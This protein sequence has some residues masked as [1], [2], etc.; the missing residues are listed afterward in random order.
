[1]NASEF[2]GWAIPQLIDA[3]ISIKLLNKSK[4]QNCGGWFSDDKKELVTC[5]KHVDAFSIFIHEFC[6]FLQFRDDPAMWNIVGTGT[7]NFF[8][9][10]KGDKATKAEILRFT[11]LA[12][13]LEHD[14]ET[15]A[16]ALIK[17]LNID[18]D[19]AAYTQ[20][21]NAYLYSYLMT[22]ELR[23]WPNTKHSIYTAAVS[24]RFDTSLA[25]LEQLKDKKN[26][27]NEVIAE[28]KAHCYNLDVKAN[29]K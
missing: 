24:N 5:T 6:H 11:H 4:Q 20:K 13:E 22:M 8:A 28:W 17:K 1:M 19:F 14:C 12:Q 16:I 18:I 3:G 15:K 29:K 21:A 2:Y 27:P 9:W 26:I 23:L 7:D 25:T 10:L